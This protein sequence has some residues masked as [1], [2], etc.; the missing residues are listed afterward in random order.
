MKPA[1]LPITVLVAAGLLAG[2]SGKSS[3]PAFCPGIAAL[4]DAARQPMLKPGGALDPS[5][6]VYTMEIVGVKGSCEYDKKG[7]DADTTVDIHFRATRAPTGEAARYIVPY[8]VA[9]TQADRIIAKQ[10]YQ[11]QIDF[12]PGSAVADVTDT[13]EA[14]H[15]TTEEGK[16]PYDYQV[17]A[18]LPLTKDQ[19]DYNRTVGRYG[20]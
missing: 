5:N 17:L 2:C 16:K 11:V 6:V 4:A 1:V 12:E 14:P 20:Q 18:G 13:A 15:I 7:H 10:T 19:L 8:F 3:K 9:V